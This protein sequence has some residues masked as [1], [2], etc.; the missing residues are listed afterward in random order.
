MYTKFL[1]S[2]VLESQHVVAINHTQHSYLVL[3]KWYLAEF[4]DCISK[5]SL[6]TFNLKL[7]SFQLRQMLSAGTCCVSL[8]QT[9]CARQIHSAGNGQMY[10][11][12]LE[13]EAILG[14]DKVHVELQQHQFY[15]RSAA[16]I[17]DI[18]SLHREFQ[19]DMLQVLMD[20]FPSVIYAYAV[21]PVSEGRPYLDAFSFVLHHPFDSKKQYNKEKDKFDDN[22]LCI[23]RNSFNQPRPLQF[24]Q[25]DVAEWIED[26]GN[27]MES[28]TS[29]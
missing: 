18:T 10:E 4:F 2:V 28:R 26:G 22:V 14:Q 9:L 8:L 23:F 12:K 24:Y 17:S 15:D 3:L 13:S 16:T 27:C 29:S 19:L 1:F 5:I 25:V 21:H 7:N 20:Y 6:S 11:H